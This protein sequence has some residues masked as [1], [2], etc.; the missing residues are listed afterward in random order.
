M[1]PKANVQIVILTGWISHAILSKELSELAELTLDVWDL[2]AILIKEPLEVAG[3][4]P[5]NRQPVP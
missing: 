4:T 1:S 2:V 5:L 3:A